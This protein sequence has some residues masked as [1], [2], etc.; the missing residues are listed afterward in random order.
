MYINARLDITV[1]F[2]STNMLTIRSLFLK[3]LSIAAA[4]LN[5]RQSEFCF[6]HFASGLPSAIA[7]LE[8]VLRSS[9]AC[10]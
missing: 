3:E 8:L 10:S 5:C 9:V 7:H 2:Y 6:R 4:A 1:M